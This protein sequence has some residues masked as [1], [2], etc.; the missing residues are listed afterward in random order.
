[1]LVAC[2]I[3][4]V[5][6]PKAAFTASQW[7]KHASDRACAQCSRQ[8]PLTLEDWVKENGA[9][10]TA[11]SLSIPLRCVISAPS[12]TQLASELVRETALQAQ[13]VYWPYIRTLLAARR[14]D[15]V[16]PPA[17]A[18]T[19]AAAMQTKR[20]Q[21]HHWA[22]ACV[23]MRAIEFNRKWLMVPLVDLWPRKRGARLEVIE[24]KAAFNFTGVKELPARGTCNAVYY[25]N[26]GQIQPDNDHFDACKIV[27]RGVT[28]CVPT[29][30]SETINS[31]DIRAM[32][33]RARGLCGAAADATGSFSTEANE[34]RA[35]QLIAECAKSQREA[36]VAHPRPSGTCSAAERDGELRVLDFWMSLH[37]PRHA[38]SSTESQTRDFWAEMADKC[39][40]YQRH[41]RKRQ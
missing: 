15:E 5:R 10:I 37:L 29:V 39:P 41:V 6:R 9:T 3:C 14:I 36:I 23:Q 11:E 4:R 32:M 24:D 20:P 12:P 34:R 28:F 40:E 30:N 19:L 35:L 38:D 18:D 2:R 1:M 27:V 13:S 31:P 25:A 33:S 16:V 8:A 17:A 21:A 7:K 22:V 26:C